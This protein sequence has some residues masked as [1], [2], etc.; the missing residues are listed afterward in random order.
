MQ[1][2][3]IRELLTPICSCGKGFD[4]FIR[5]LSADTPSIQK[6]PVQF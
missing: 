4:R 3:S 5:K 2:P 6:L 1:A